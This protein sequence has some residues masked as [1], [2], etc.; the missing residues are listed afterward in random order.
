M[1]G[2]LSVDVSQGAIMI[3]SL[4]DSGVRHGAFSA[5]HDLGGP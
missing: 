3:S 1:W 5:H 2:Q 4:A